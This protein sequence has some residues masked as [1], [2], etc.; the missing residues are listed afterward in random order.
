M[1]CQSCTAGCLICLLDN[2]CFICAN[3]YVLDYN[4]HLCRLASN[5]SSNQYL[6]IS[7]SCLNCSAN[8]RTCLNQS[9]LCTSCPLS[10]STSGQT[11]LYS[12]SCVN[13]CPTG[14]FAHRYSLT[15][16]LCNPLCSSC[17][18]FDNCL[19]CKANYFI[20]NFYSP[21]NALCVA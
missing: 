18:N 5:C 19:T 4:T 1:Q 12:G 13:S 16:R 3:N 9:T 10:T 20:L 14:F 17:S 7:S 21:Q 11:Y 6:D 15:C 2:S 8:C